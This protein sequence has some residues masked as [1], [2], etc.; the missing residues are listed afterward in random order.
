MRAKRSHKRKE[1]HDRYRIVCRIVCCILSS[2]RSVLD[3]NSGGM[4][5]A[6]VHCLLMLP[7]PSR[8][9]LRMS[10]QEVRLRDVSSSR[11]QTA[12]AAYAAAAAASSSVVTPP[13]AGNQRP[14]AF[15][16]FTSFALLLCSS[17]RSFTPRPS[18]SLCACSGNACVVLGRQ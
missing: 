7:F 11:Q 10:F 14:D 16:F 8:F 3:A 1:E 5:F 12:A 9:S 18:S 17:C 15:K 6:P 13:R 4:D 2:L